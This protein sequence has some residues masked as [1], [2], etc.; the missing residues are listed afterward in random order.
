MSTRD[1]GNDGRPFDGRPPKGR[2]AA[3]T[4]PSAGLLALR[5]TAGNAAAARAV[6]EERHQHDAHCGHAPAVQRSSPVHEV[7][8]APGRPLGTPLR[9]ETEARFEG[10][11]SSGVR[12]HSDAVA[13]R[14]AHETEAKAYTSGS[15]IVDGGDMPKED[16]AHEPTHHLDQRTGPVPGTDDGSG[17]RVSDPSGSGERRAVENARRTGPAPTGRRPGSGCPVRRGRPDAEPHLHRTMNADSCARLVPA[18]NGAPA[19]L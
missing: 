8:R 13:Q 17:P 16:R 15:H 14:S 3:T 11:D 18:A 1:K 19:P 5:R 6:A 7:L 4:G 9:T 2:P 12:V 10:A